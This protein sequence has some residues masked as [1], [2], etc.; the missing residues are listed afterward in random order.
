MAPLYLSE[1]QSAEFA[2]AGMLRLPDYFPQA[3]AA[4]LADKLWNDLRKRFGIDRDRPETW[5]VERPAQYQDLIKAGAF[6]ALGDGFQSIADAFLGEG[7]WERPRNLGQPL[8]TFQSRSWDV[9]HNMW[10]LDVPAQA[11]GGGLQFVFVFVLLG[12]IEPR[13]GGTCYVEASHRFIMQSVRDSN[14]SLRSADVKPLLEREPW[15]AAL[16]SKSLSENRTRRLLDGE[17]VRGVEVR[18][19]EITGNAGDVFVMHPA[20]LH[21]AAPNAC[22]TPRMM[23]VQPLARG[24]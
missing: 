18:V 10:H 11:D 9:P 24:R 12:R 7:A 22:A 20:T 23:L 16:F 6:N 13:G 17:T 4:G 5:S 8:V 2:R 3:L 21:T 1:E 15:F 14:G 19:A